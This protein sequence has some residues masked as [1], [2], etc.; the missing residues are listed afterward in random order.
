LTTWVAAGEKPPRFAW[1]AV[2]PFVILAAAAVWLYLGWDR[3]P[4]RFPVH[5]GAGGQPN[6]WAERTVMGVYGCLLYGTELC[7]WLAAMALAGWYGTR[8]SRARPLMLGV[9]VAV[10]YLLGVLLALTAL[11]PLL[12]TPVWVIVLLPV[13]VVIPTLLVVIRKMSGV[14][15]P[16]TVAPAR[17]WKA[18]AFYWNPADAALF[19]P[20][21]DG[22]GYTL[23]MA[24][25]WAWVLLGTL[26]LVIASAWFVLP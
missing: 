24:N 6:R 3:I 22:L 4:A 11:E 7:T 2:G 23:N 18:G 25:R 14:R 9:L 19:V 17:C 1:L 20:K 15:E 21:R 13:V 8:R 12:A 16:L 5:W 26:A 10:E